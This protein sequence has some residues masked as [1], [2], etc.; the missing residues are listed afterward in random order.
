MPTVPVVPGLYYLAAFG[1]VVLV[2]TVLLA[3]FKR[4]TKRFVNRVANVLR[5]PFTMLQVDENAKL[6]EA[7]SFFRGGSLGLG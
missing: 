1:G 2:S 5:T 6:S 4:T 3:P 7:S